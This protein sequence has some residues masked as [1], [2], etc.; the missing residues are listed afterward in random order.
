MRV[1]EKKKEEGKFTS[2]HSSHPWYIHDSPASPPSAPAS[3]FAAVA[4]AAAVV[5]A[6]ASSPAAAGL[7]SAST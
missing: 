7:G 3:S 6:A 5:V 4:A 2:S 1:R